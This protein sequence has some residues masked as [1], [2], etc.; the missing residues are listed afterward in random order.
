LIVSGI[1]ADSGASTL[2]FV[3]WT[4]LLAFWLAIQPAM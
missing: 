4:P 2:V 3:A 1:F